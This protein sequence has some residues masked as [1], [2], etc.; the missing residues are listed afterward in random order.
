MTGPGPD[1][2]AVAVD[3]YRAAPESFVA[4]RDALAKELKAQ[5]DAESAAAVKA[6]RRPT[7]GAWAVNQAAREEPGLVGALE[8]AGERLAEAQRQALSGERAADELRE[9]GAQRREVV[10]RLTEVAVRALERAGRPSGAVRDEIAATFEA[11]TLDPGVGA[12]VRAGILDRTAAPVSGLGAIAGFTV[13]EGGAASTRR[14]PDRDAAAER[15][16]AERLVRASERADATAGEA[17]G[18]ATRARAAAEEAAPQ[19]EVLE[20]AARDAEREAKRL[21]SEAK[22][23][24]ARA[25]RATRRLGDDPT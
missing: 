8:A 3:L 25:E 17:Q 13:L 2:P 5:G 22:T 23:A 14:T 20:A 16:E 10:R 21:A 6:L 18:R 15:A 24:R 9:A 19:A 12:R 7:V 4:S 11:A 1:L